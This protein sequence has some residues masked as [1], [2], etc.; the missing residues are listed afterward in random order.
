MPGLPKAR[1]R[2]AGV[3]VFAILVVLAVLWALRKVP[4]PSPQ[5]SREPVNTQGK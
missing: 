2:V 1:R 5:E 4:P 3:S